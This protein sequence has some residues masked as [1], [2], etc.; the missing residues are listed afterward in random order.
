MAVEAVARLSLG[1]RL[2]AYF[3]R[4]PVWKLLLTLAPPLSWMLIV[5]LGALILL[6]VTALWHVNP[7]TSEVEPAWSLENFEKIVTQDVYRTIALRTLR[8]ALAVTVVDIALAFPIA[9]YMARIARGRSRNILLVAVV[10]PLWTNYLVRVFAWKTILGGNGP[11]E[12]LLR[13]LGIGAEGLGTSELAV[14]ITFC[15]LWLPFVILP[16]YAALE[17]VPQSLLD[18]SGDLGAKGWK[19]F[20]SVVWPL[21]FPGVMAA[22]I[23]AF[24]LTL[25]DYITPTLVGKGFFIGNTI[26]TYVG[27]A[28]NLPLAAAFA[29]VPVVIVAIYMTVARKLG[30]FEAL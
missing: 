24:S 2:S 10:V 28:N 30:A 29:T 14:G 12:S 11:A 3:N 27:T 18:A 16:I 15:Y 22:S 23:F 19:T 6:F 25:G 7:L 13:I 4:H 9:F 1:R 5:Y 8:I 26:Y 20:R 21:A 17:R